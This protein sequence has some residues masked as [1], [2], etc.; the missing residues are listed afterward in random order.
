MLD[1][2]LIWPLAKTATRAWLA[3]RK[4]KLRPATPLPITRTSIG[5]EEGG[6]EFTR[7]AQ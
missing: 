4:A 1:P 2:S 5:A 7:V 3:R 6:T